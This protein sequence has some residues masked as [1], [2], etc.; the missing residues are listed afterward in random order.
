MKIKEILIICI[1][2]ICCIFSFQAV[3]AADDGSTTDDMVLT[4]TDVSAYSLPNLDNQL[5]SGSGDAGSFSDL[6]NDTKNGG[7]ITLDRNYTYNSSSDSGLAGGISITK[8]TVID[9]QGI[10]TI[11]ANNMARVFTIAKGTTVTLKGIIFINANPASGHGG[12]IFA[13]GVVHIDN[14]IFINNTANYANGGAVC[15]AGLGSTITNSYFEGN[16]AINNGNDNNGAAGAVFINANN[17]SI[18]NSI[19]IKN[20]AGLNGGAI[21]SSAM[22]VENSIITN[23]TITN[24]T[25]NGSAG[26]IGMQS[27]NFHIYNS[28]FKYN[29]AKGLF[30]DITAK[31]YYP[32][33]GG[34][35]VM[36]GWDS[37][38]YNCTFIGNIAKQHGGATFSTNTSYNPSNNNT[39]FELCTF[40]DNTAGS[41]GGAVDWAAGATYGYIM[42]STFINNT[43]KRSGGA[44]HW[45]GHY[46]TVSNSTFINNNATGEVISVIGG[47]LG[48]GDG[49]AIVWVGSHGIINDSCNFTSNYAK[50]RGGAIYIHGNAT[51]NSTNVTIHDSIFIDNY[52]GINGGAVDWHDGSHDGAIYNSIFENNI[53]GSNGGAV[54]WSG[55]HGDIWNSNFTNN[56]AK[57]LLMDEHGNIGDGGAV[58]W[59]GM[60]GTVE[61]C[62]FIDNIANQ[63]GGAVYLQNCTH[64]SC[65]NTTFSNS[66]FINNAAGLNGGA[67]DWHEGA[68][69]GLVSYCNFE[70]NI[71]NRSA[72]AIFWSGH[73]GTVEYSNFT[74]NK[75]LGIAIGPMPNGTLTYGGD[76]GAIMWT[77]AIG[78]VK[79]SL[80]SDNGAV[81]RGGAIF[82]QEGTTENCYNTT[83]SNSKFIN[84]F[85]GTNGG[86]IDWHRGA[87]NGTIEYCLFENNI[88][89]RSAGAVFWNGRNGTIIHSNF[90]QNEAKGI[91]WAISVRGENNTG[92]DGGAIMW[93]GSVG[94]VDDCRF[95]D[96]TAAERGGGI[97][98]Q[99]T[100]IEDCYNT[101]F[102][103]SYFEGNVAGDEGGAI[104][105]DIGSQNGYVYNVEF[106][107]NTAYTNGGAIHWNGY[108]GTIKSSTFRN[109]RATGDVRLYNMSL[110]LDDI[111]VY[112]NELPE[113][114]LWTEDKL[115]VLVTND[116][117]KISKFGLYVT[118]NDGHGHHWV[119][120]DE[121]PEVESSPVDWAV[122]EFFGGDGGSIIWHGDVA[123]IDNCT[124][125]DSNSARRGGAVY[126]TGGDYVEFTKCSFENCTSGTNGGGLAWFTGANY[127]KVIDCNFTNTHAAR[128]AGAIYYDGDNGEMRNIIIKNTT[129]FGGARNESEDG[130]VKYVCWDLSHWD[131]NTTGGDGGAMMFTGDHI[132]VYNVNFTDCTAAGR[133]GAIFVQDNHN[134]TIDSCTF[135]NNHA[136]GIANNTYND[137]HDPSSGINHNLTGH[138]GAIAFD[139]GAT[140]SSIVSSI[141]NN[142]TA[143]LYGGAVH[144]RE[145]ASEDKV[146]NSAFNNNY[147]SEDGGALF[148]D[149][150]HCELHDS[151]FNHNYVGDDGGAIYWHGQGGIINNINCTNNTGISSHGNSKG[152]TICLTGNDILLSN[153]RFEDSYA[154]VTGGAMFVTGNNV[155]ITGTSF[156]NCNVSNSTGGALQ[157]LGNNTQVRDCT[158]EDCHAEAGSAIYTEGNYVK[159]I[160][161]KFTNNNVTGDG[162]AVYVFGDYSELHNSTFIS[163]S[164]GDDGGAIY[165]EGNHGIIYNIT[166]ENNNGISF[167][168]S[169]SKGGTICITGEDISISSSSFKTSS[170]GDD[171]GAIFISGNNVDIIG[172]D[173]EA[174][175]SSSEGGAIYVLGDDSTISDCTFENCNATQGGAIYIEG[176]NAMVEGSNFVDSSSVLNGG[177]IYVSGDMAVIENSLINDTDAVYGGGIYISG[178]DVKVDGTEFINL[179]SVEDG[180]AIYI[181]GQRGR[182]YNSKFINNTAG[183]D[184]GAINWDGNYGI[185]DNI[186]CENNRGISFNGSSSNGGTISLT[187]NDTSISKSSFSQSYALI[188]GGAIFVTGNNVNITDSEFENCY[189]S[190]DMAETNKTYANGGGAIYLFGD[191]SNVVNCNFDNSTGREGG[192]IYVQGNEVT[193]DK[194][195]FNDSFALNGGAIYING[196]YTV[197]SNSA[198]D[199]SNATYSGGAVFI[200]GIEA[201][202]INSSFSNTNAFGS[203]GNGGGA[204]YIEGENADVMGSN[205][206]NTYANSNSHAKGGAMYITGANAEI[207]DS[208]FTNAHSNLQ[209]GAIYVDGADT[210]INGSEFYN[211]MVDSPGSQGGAIYI[212]GQHTIVEDSNFVNSSSVFRGGSIYID[213]LNAL[214]KDSNFT[215]SS[216]T[217]GQYS[218]QN[219]RGGSVYI[220]ENYAT[221]EGSI[222]SH[223]TVSKDYGEGGAI[224]IEGN[225]AHVT[226]SSVNGSSANCGGALYSTGS[227]SKVEHSNFTNNYAKLNGGALYWYGASNSKNNTVDGCIFINNTA[228]GYTTNTDIT[229]GGGA[230]FWSE[231]GR[232]GSVLNSKFYN[233]SVISIN[234]KKV[235]G[236][237]ILWDKSYNALVENCTFVGNFVT[238]EGDGGGT[239]ASA[240][241]A[242]GGAMYLRPMDDYT[243]RNCLFENCSSSKEAG[244]LYIQ[245]DG[246][247]TKTLIE[248]CTFINNVAYGKGTANIN[249]GGAMQ[250]KQATNVQLKNVT[251]INNTANKGGALCVFDGTNNLVV[252][253]ANFTSNKAEKGS[254][255]SISR[256]FIL[257]D[258]VLLENRADTT[259]F[260]LT[261][262]RN[263][264]NIDILME[265]ADTHLNAIYMYADSDKTFFVTLNNVT[266]WTDNNISTGKEEVISGDMYSLPVKKLPEAGIDVLVE[267]FDGDNKKLHEG[268]YATDAD[269]KIHLNIADIVTEPYSL[270]N[271]YVNARLLNEDYYTMA[272]KTSRIQN[273]YVDASALD[274]IFHRNTTVTANITAPGNGTGQA[275][276]GTVSVYIDDVFKGNMTIENSKGSLENILT[277]VTA[278]KFFEVGNHTIFLKYW[279]DA[280]FGEANK[281]ISFNI[282][283][284]QSNITL[285]Y[286]DIGYDF[287]VTVTIVDEFNDVNYMDA[288]GTVIIDVYNVGSTTVIKSIPVNIVNSTG[289]VKITELLP[290]NYT[291]VYHYS[292]DKNYNAS[293]NST[294]AELHKKADAIVNITVNAYDIMVNETVYINITLIVPPKYEATGNV[295]LYLDNEKYI[296]Q[297]NNSR[298]YFNKTGLSE[299][300]KIVTV[301]YDGSDLLIPTSSDATFRVLKYNT[302]LSV[303]TTNITHIQHEV[304]NIT[305]L[306]DTVGVVSVFINDEEYFARINNGTAILELPLLPVGEYNVTVVFPGDDKYNNNTIKSKFKVS[307]VTPDVNIEVENVTYGDSTRIVVSIIDCVEG[308]VTI[309]IDGTQYGNPK[310]VEN[311]RVE[312]VV[313]YLTAGNYTLEALYSGDI[314]HTASS[315]EKDFA[316][317]KANRTII[318]EVQNITY[319]DIEHIKVYVNAT[320]NVTIFV[321]GRNVTIELNESDVPA[322]I[323]RA[324]INTISEY[325]GK[326]A[327]DVYNLNVGKYPVDVVYNGNE[328]YNKA[329]ARATFIVSQ[330]NTNLVIDTHRI[331]VWN[332]EYIN[333]TV[334]NSTG[335]IAVNATGKIKL[336]IDGV[337]QTADIVD[338]VARFNTAPSSVGQKVVWAFYDGD[339]NYIGNR[340][341]TTFDVT[342]R[343]PHMNISAQNIIVGQN[344]NI[345]VQLPENAT[346]YVEIEV[347]GDNNYYCEVIN[348]HAAAYPKNLKEGDYQVYVIY[349]GDQHDN[350]TSVIKET[351]FIV[352]K[353]K[354]NVTIDVNDTVYDN[355]VNIV[356]YVD[357]GVEGNISIKLDNIDL[358]TY[359]IVDGKVNITIDNPG[360]G[361]YTV[362]AEYN[363]NNKYNVNKTESKGF[364]VD[365]ATPTIIIDKVTVDANTNATI[366]VRINETASGKI[367]IT[368]NG[369]K[370]TAAIENGVATFTIDKLLAGKYNITAEYS[371]DNNYTSVTGKTL[372]D[373]LIVTKVDCYQI[374]VTA[375][376]TKV[377]LN[378]TII[379]RV[380][381]DAKGNVS[382]YINDLFEGNATI[383]GG[384][385]MLNVT[386]PYGNYTVN[387]TFSD[388]KYGER[389]AI[390]DFWVFKHDS[391]LEI[392]VDSIMV[393]DKAYINVTA[394]SDNVTI[395]IDGKTYTRKS[396][397][398]GVAYFEVS[399]LS[400]GNKTVTAIYGGSDKY[401]INSTTADF[402]VNKYNTAINIAVEDIVYGDKVN[403]T[404]TVN[405][406]A[407]G[408]ITIRINETRNV[409]LPI[410]N[411]K[412]N[413]IVEGLAVENYTVYADYSGNYKFNANSTSTGFNVTKAVPVLSIDNIVSVDAATNATIIVRINETATGNIT[414]TV[415]NTKY[416]AT[417]KNGVAVFVINKLLA[418]TYEV[419]AEYVGDNNYTAANVVSADLVVT[420]VDCYQINVTADD[421]KVG[422]NTTIVVNVPADAEGNVSIYINGSFAGNA[423]VN[424]GVAMLNVT[425]PYGNYTINATFTD[426]KYGERYAIAD[427][428]VFKHDSPLVIDVDS[429]LVGDKAYI[430][431]TAPSDNVTIEINGKSYN[432]VKYENGVAYFEVAGLGAGNKTVVALYG[433]SD[434]YVQNAT[435]ANF[436]VDKCGTDLEVTVIS[437]INVRENTTV[438][439]ILPDDAKGYVVVNV[440]GKNYTINLTAGQR[441]VEISGLKN[442]TYNV[443]ATYLG[444]DKY[445]SSINNTQVIKVNKVPSSINL[446]VSE[447][448]IIA[449]G[450]D[451]N[452]TIDVPI[453]ATG[454]VIVK[455]LNGTELIR[456]Y[457]VYV[458]E[459]KGL[460]HLDSPVIGLYN[461]TAEYLGD[462]KYVESENKTSFEVFATDGELNVDADNVFVNVNN[463]ITVTIPGKHEGEVTIIVSNASGVVIRQNATITP[464]DSLSHAE[465][466]LRLLDAGKYDVK[467]IFIEVNGTITKVYEGNDTF[468]VYKLASNIQIEELNATIFVG[469][470]E[471]IK[472]AIDLDPRANGGNISVF[473]NG[474]EYNTTT[475]KLTLEIPDLNADDYNVKVIYHGNNWYNESSATA[476]FKVVKNLSPMTVNVTN[477]SVG[478]VE[479]INVTLPDN[480]TGQV[481]LDI[482]GQQYYAN[483]TEG[484]AQFNITGLKAGEYKFNV[485]YIGD[486]KYL[487]NNTNSALKVSKMQPAFAV[488]GTNITFGSG[489]LIKFETSDNITSLV[490]VEIDNKNYT[491]FIREGKGNLT[492][493]NLAAGDYNITL[494]FEGNEKYLNASAKNNFTVLKATPEIEL[495]VVNITYTENE[496][497]VVYVDAVGDVT[498]RIGSYINTTAL[499]DGKAVFVVKDLAAGDYTANATFNGNVNLTSVSA[500]ADF[501]V[502]KATPDVNVIVENITYYSP[503]TIVVNVNTNGNVTIKVNGTVKGEE[504]VIDNG[505]VEL[506][507]ND[508]AAGVYDVEVIYNGNENY[509]SAT[510]NAVFVV[511]QAPTSIEVEVGN[512]N[513]TGKEIINVTISNV[514]ATGDVIINVDGV[515]YTRPIAEGKANLTLDKLTNGTHSIVVVYVGDRN[516]TGN[517]TSATFE[518]NKLGSELTINVT[519]IIVR[520]KEII[521]VNVTEGATGDVIITV[522]GKDYKVE[523]KNGF[524]TLELDNLANGTY[525]VHVKYL[526]DANYSECEGDASFNVSKVQSNINLTVSDYGIVANGSDVNITIEAPIDATGKVNVTV[527]DGVQNKTYI[528]YVNDGIGILHLETP[529]VG[530]YNVT[531]KYLG[532]DKYI[533]SE[534]KTEFEVYNTGKELTV[535]TESIDFGSD[536]IILIYVAGNHQGKEV[537]IIVKDSHGNIVTKENSTFDKYISIIN[538]TSARLTL[539]DLNA[540]EYT[541]DAF[542]LEINGTKVIEHSGS[543]IFEV[544]K[545]PS[546]LTIKEIRN[547]TVGENVT[548][549]LELSP[550]TAAGN[551]SVFVNGIEHKTNTSNLT[552][553]IP[554]LGAEEYYVHA[555]YYGDKNHIGSNASAEFKVSKNPIPIVINVTNSKVGEV[556]QINVTL[557]E[558]AT[559]RVLLEIGNNHYYADVINGNVT[560]NINKLDAGKYN[561]TVIYEG[562]D[563]YFTNQSNSSF[564]VSKHQPEFAVNGTNITFGRDELIKFETVSNITSAVKVE[565]NGKNYTAFINEGKGNLTVY[566]LAAGD[567]NITLYFEGNEKYLNASAKN[568]FAVLKAT[569]EIELSVVNITYTENETVVVYVDAVGDVT[570]RI[571]S[572]INTTALVDGKAVFVVKDLAAGDYTANATYNGNTNLTSVSTEADFTVAKA[573]PD[574]I[575]NVENITYYGPETIVVNV[576][577]NGNVTIKV[578]GT[579]KGEELIIDNGKVELKVNDLAAGVYDVE[580]IYNGNNNYTSATVNAV[581][582]VKQAPVTVDVEVGDIN[583]IGKE[584]INVTI[585]NV[586]ATGDVIINVDGVNYTRPI[587]E[588][589]ANLTLDKLSNG[590][591][592]VVVIYMGDR[593][594]TG[595]WS[596]KTFNVD[597]LSS[598]LT[599][600]VTNINVNQKEIIKVNVTEGATGTVVIT[601]DGVNHYVEIES[602][603][604]ILELGD[605]ANKTYLVHAKYLGD[606]NYTGC[607]GD[608]SFN[609]SKVPSN[610][611][612]K[613]E[614]ITLGDVAVVNITV[615]VNATGNV[616]I[617]IGDEY[618]QTVG[619]IDGVISVIVPDLSVGNK[620]VNVTYNGD[621]RFL[622]STN[623]T[624]FTVGKATKD[625]I[626]IVENITYTE[627]ETVTVY[628]DA[629]GNVTLRIAEIGY[630][631]T[632][633]LA[634]GKATF[635]INGLNA[636]NYTVEATFNGNNELNSTSSAADFTVFKAD[637]IITLE[638]HNIIYGD[639][640]HI[641]VHVNAEGN[642]TIRVNGTTETIVLRTDDSG[643]VILRAGPQDDISSYDGKAHEYIYNLKPGQYPVEVTYNGNE[644]YNTA[645]TSDVFYVSKANS[646]IN[647]DVDDIDVG[648]VA[649][650]NVTLPANATGNVTIE[651]NG[652]EYKPESF[653]D[654]V[655]KF[656]V[657]NLTHGNKTVA[658][659]YSGDDN[660]TA[661]STTAQFTVSKVTPQITINVTDINVGDKVLI[662]VTA[663]V[664]VTNPVLVDVGGVGY[665]VNI[666]GGKGELYVSNLAHGD[667]NATARYPGDEKYLSA[668]NATG[669]K[670]SKVPSSVNV[671]VENITFGENAVINVETPD[672]LLGNV[673][674]SVDGKD[675]TVPVSG[676]KGILVVPGLSVGPHSVDVIFDGSDKY[677]PN[678]NSTQ[679]NVAKDKLSPDDIKVIDKGNGTVVVVVPNNATGNVT[680]KVGDKEFNATVVNGTAV[681]EL[682]NVTPGEHEIEVIYSGDD[683]YDNATVNSTVVVPKLESSVNVTCDV[684][685]D[686][687]VI[688]V[689]APDDATGNVTIEVDGEKYT[690]PIEDGIATLEIGNLTAGTKTIAVDY[691][692]DDNYG[693][694][695]T[696]ANV[697]VSKLPSFVNATIS[698]IKAGENV[699]IEVSV[700]ENATGQVLIDIDGVG[701]YVNITD[702]KGVVEIP[703]I[704]SG[705]HNVTLTYAGDDKYESASNTTGFE[706][707]KVPSSVNV[708]V[709]NITFGE[710]AVI[711]V[712]TPDDLLGNV[713][714]S[715]DGKDYTVPVSGGKGILVVPGLSV[716][717]HSVDVIFDGSDKYEPNSNSTQF[718]VAK[719]KLSPD[720]IKVIDKGNGTVVVVVP[721]N[722]TGNVTVKVG[723]KEF[724]ATVVNGTA[725]V[726]LDNVTPGEHEIEVIYSGD[727]NYDN[728]T[729]NSTVVVPKLESS[730][731][732]TCDVVGDKAV[733]TV[734]APDDATGNVTIEV[735]GEK[736]TVP[737]EDGI[738]TLEIG[739]L[740]AGTKTIAVDYP[741]DDNYGSTHTTANVTVS[742]LPSFVNATISDIKAGENVTIEVSVPENA[743]G[744]VLIDI[745]GVGYYVNITD[746]KGVVEIPNI[747]SGKHNVTLTYAGDDKYESAS[748][749]T[750]FEVSKLPSDINVSVEN[751]NFGENAVINV[752]TPDDLLGNVT[753]TVD[754]KDYIVPVSGGKGTLVVPGL[755]A[756]PHSVEV[757]FNGSDKYESDSD[758]ASFNVAKAELSPDDI[759]VIDKGN[760]T[761]VVVVPNNATGNVTV[762]IGNNT[763][764]A[765]VKDGIAT[766]TLDNETPGQKE[767]EIIYSGDD[768][769][770]NATVNATVTVYKVQTPISINVDDIRVGDNALVKVN[771][772]SD[773]TGSVTIEID[774]KS[775]TAPVVNGVATFEVPDLIA[776]DKTV[777]A[778][779]GGDDKYL[780][781]YTTDTFTVSKCP[782]TIDVVIFDI[783]VGENVTVIVTLPSDATGQ[784]LIDIDGVGYYVNLTD[785][786]G[787]ASIPR[788]PSGV[789]NVNVT[790]VGDA[791]YLPNSTKGDVNVTKLKSFVIPSA[792]DIM[793][794]DDEILTFVVPSDATG[795]LI[796]DDLLV[797]SIDT[798][799][800]YIIDIN[801]GSGELTVSGLPEGRYIVTVRYDGDE[802]YLPSDN[803][804]TFKVSKRIADLDVVDYGN[805]TV[806]VSVPENATGTITLIIENQTYVANI[807]DGKAVFYLENATPGIQ[808]IKVIYSGDDAYEPS[809]VDSTAEIPKYDTPVSVSSEDI[810]FGDTETITINLP[811]DATGTVTIEIDGKTY[812]ANVTDGKAVFNIPG[813]TVGNKTA[814]IRYSGDDNYEATETTV[815]FTVNKCEAPINAES[816]DIKVGDDATITVTFP[817]D[818]TGRAILGLAGE[819][820]Y[821]D[822]IDGKAVFTI[823]KLASGEYEATVVYEGDDKYLP[824]STVVSFT[825]SKNDAPA[826]ATGDDI[827][828][829]DDGTVVVTLPSDATGTV[830]IVV[831]GKSYTAPVVNGKAV[832]KIPGLT[833]GVHIVDV[834]YSG[835]DKYAANHTSTRIIVEDNSDNPGEE[836]E[837]GI[838]VYEETSLAKYPTGNPILILLLMLL[839]VIGVIPL[840][841]FKKE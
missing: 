766:I 481:L 180:G 312:F 488:N 19:F 111:E 410:V 489:E 524:A 287:H 248:N 24:N 103:N 796:V 202:I 460:L 832:F 178:N 338:G 663:P 576:N 1:I 151:T 119:L 695:H 771:L 819:E 220:N 502:A 297:L 785:G 477:S 513:V 575:V 340:A 240:V 198:V 506:I 446:T 646:T 761:I 471:T 515:N 243:V 163:N 257:N 279:G 664:D 368:V 35:M 607:E 597:R 108:N 793:V 587:A 258:A 620:T 328:N 403:I 190:M 583:V 549:E 644:N 274:T 53:A 358:G 394:P 369:T 759:K 726:E 158:F 118:T 605:L 651:I 704:S 77:G 44:I 216:V 649:L 25:A 739:N 501:N 725:V 603:F 313:E 534:N 114:S 408:F 73:N 635:I 751:I 828:I 546:E 669:F 400:Y 537:E 526:G 245:S 809:T 734:T 472:L 654:G 702:G 580:V 335:G 18:S 411:G 794:G 141:F 217:G 378:S 208:K 496:T 532:D 94:L 272:K 239:G 116:G 659:T 723:D 40:I 86:A 381:V 784:V 283:K 228:N 357:D 755:S 618:K 480:A 159:V 130:K 470:N 560:F 747:S 418:G 112:D 82:L 565:I 224:F 265:G 9:G 660:Y 543:S 684:V 438:T 742:K 823:P 839:M 452:I 311:G 186:V 822:I 561:F 391:P 499:V 78:D 45:S 717:P 156:K 802:K 345:T 406:T 157:L 637:P 295:T 22:M 829:G 448:G 598:E 344:G 37:Y 253:G 211:C 838:P 621:G 548:I 817:K 98:L 270:D 353:A 52:A 685:G 162:G 84:N 820:Y 83:F 43:A 390:A 200:K 800:E 821:A 361:S 581:F 66:I 106:V 280:Y 503:E 444:D 105:W 173:F 88:A 229:R 624:N 473:V 382:I 493:Y 642:V 237:A 409:T 500:E 422:L 134:V 60:N 405:N 586:N 731:N 680:V 445:L 550:N 527:F 531:A 307:Q 87:A 719:D 754:G 588:G 510:V 737:I 304:I 104:N 764:N 668:E 545:L 749:T 81:K 602:G 475:S 6:Q 627:N 27:K 395:E 703:N 758:S 467:A 706:V 708:S 698:D 730:V 569:P 512:I 678:S 640:E 648:D 254:A 234:K 431:V 837:S 681:V 398:D 456:S 286:Y 17:T 454:K 610:I 31:P 596:S 20:M 13:P 674:V 415:N 199:D 404:V 36:R 300:V 126:M 686:K 117:G 774:G 707:S 102:K 244:A 617:T 657:E 638:V 769:Y 563:K 701:Y 121:T 214:V 222:F 289:F 757:V 5:Q 388:G 612:V 269:G 623:S 714:V 570:L 15:L 421:T 777:V 619:L 290:A 606:A 225:N 523:I 449:Q 830:T 268:I 626:L 62:R 505:K 318:I 277:N 34:A 495:S 667:Y 611:R 372:V 752:E 341:I 810:S 276:R 336:Y 76:G 136:L 482:N 380:P 70:N 432:K 317:Y 729:V 628:V 656:K 205:F 155:N 2:I 643:Y 96:N 363:G 192:A 294:L 675:Y 797:I 645:S 238:T 711:N 55:H 252:T 325:K 282:T 762:K 71:A 194:S 188:S 11:D 690:V 373:G 124:F 342:Q 582:V 8:D 616:T 233:N 183:D 679:F 271:I 306:N 309:K 798:G 709:E 261:F 568:N 182:L 179:Y 59:S 465:L 110:T 673:T 30:D 540:G 815:N 519:D 803:S 670:V 231:Q 329:T 242:Q 652:K 91:A 165:W 443:N 805:R 171:G 592:S 772:P 107:N 484:L 386:R 533:G 483:I 440:D 333:V 51:E 365:K 327:L 461:V 485:T 541:V 147:A 33:N 781:N 100:E 780:S 226:D 835:D 128:S 219:S 604:A 562:D 296:L 396:Y 554:N 417:I 423:T 834:Y 789:Y 267:I 260:D 90:T 782:A 479:Q 451:V 144:F 132:T 585:S 349:H 109:N 314:N 26:G 212:H 195:S 439:V 682:D 572:Y 459:G 683:N 301:C 555:I 778:S 379:V 401:V 792:E 204:I 68:S 221:I 203:E 215:D 143:K 661:N 97:F 746:G 278:D 330:V 692:G 206:T 326:A 536:E 430:N 655:A 127:G 727:D 518:V 246:K 553:T 255:I 281:T 464:D 247:N 319:G 133:G 765:T 293:L 530:I 324:I 687:A 99:G 95:I 786:V 197:I 813:L 407:G 748:N 615:I 384:V 125:I 85:A 713:T 807:T 366:V 135:E 310:P 343:N 783:D 715:V 760:N 196:T 498:L 375:N 492:V 251:F 123:H 292:G 787:V 273:V 172:S 166:C 591:H 149:G 39:G 750:G 10:V 614:N 801:D 416:N 350:Y 710:N 47:I 122:D 185:I 374:N 32:G 184:G 736:Y 577:T 424:N 348:G 666:T 521:K 740:T 241:W 724:N 824:N 236:G 21:G 339:I 223:S 57:G 420:K 818:A 7:S 139:T 672:D 744:Q 756:G 263:A 808:G 437:P 535:D 463:T 383:N 392:N 80:F 427:F 393:D 522:A 323:L 812:T 468:E 332:T 232:S 285:D 320:G 641:I 806:V 453:D 696:T 795:K 74:F 791:K 639:V 191:S 567:Y 557:L 528:V 120:L 600:N 299:G 360:A 450:N 177:A 235:D 67:I 622:T 507:V 665:Y 539:K 428:W 376:D 700:P 542:Y 767:I 46:G 594:L 634:D 732:V 559:G 250:I 721:N 827:M 385:A 389:Y 93:S 284:A 262:N 625:I 833:V 763:Y 161:S 508:L 160:N 137:P 841:K 469:E 170:A 458:N 79:N 419:T 593:N 303:N 476:S 259:K 658:V 799:N 457:T 367:N 516:L 601:V 29:E 630:V 466:T 773:A 49:G 478:S 12:S 38:A 412:V 64:G 768:N 579:V 632:T 370:Y 776:G 775:Y 504:L 514:N 609:V 181:T 331:P 520:Q 788:I 497:V 210:I 113:P 693:S 355:A 814:T 322:T 633:D 50:N 677:E 671:S 753:V 169:N 455:L 589:K 167:N 174:C 689:T 334:R 825:V 146:I 14:C 447:N 213:G 544:R 414:I 129:A 529:A 65:D 351:Y 377:G 145:G 826:S 552:I 551:I 164:A 256:K 574:V 41:N 494:Y 356:V 58:I 442:S 490:K 275:A 54:F 705:K 511:K 298:A 150:N 564:V 142:N 697:T 804:T 474:A 364:T 573:A 650:I 230:I 436:T 688:T 558:N 75:A 733:I 61:N 716:G 321:D 371:G 23:C 435:T 566:D 743:T 218:N 302:T 227:N 291:L 402:T 811:E 741:G 722:A 608:A 63:R 712:E 115:Y 101:T 770:D 433:G 816:E 487:D 249:G 613:V 354:A 266:Y 362:Y 168:D 154:K 426:G 790:Y 629:V 16:R 735:D 636:G 288:N 387:V 189:V 647:V 538:G 691:P 193:I 152:G 491:A 346:G 584:I 429:I 56:M 308:N 337:E 305:L 148:I 89:N 653:I 779:Y 631:N 599:I 694:T 3:S 578:N 72:G 359:G 836:N 441:S 840:R 831:D 140:E 175:N 556:E 571:G 425:R 92:G 413:W 315:A 547:I 462:D 4:S 676:G 728:A 131:T 509:T 201:D 662:E 595:N 720:D 138:G 264:G 399:G 699:T 176:K 486:Y 316:V 48:G 718:N 69:H 209:G 745:D 738:A 397:A 207:A 347:L 434:K 352:S 187:G 517:W 42:D 590:T 28:T 525:D 153:S